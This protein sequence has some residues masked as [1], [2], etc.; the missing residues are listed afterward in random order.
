M[1]GRVVALDLSARHNVTSA[2]RDA[3]ALA[4]VADAGLG[5]RLLDVSDC[6]ALVEAVLDFDLV[7][8]AVPGSLGF[9]TLEAVIRAGRNVVDISFFPENALELQELATEHGVVAIVDSGVA[10][11]LDNLILGHHDRTMDVRS[12]E[13][14]VGGLPKR[15]KWPFEYKAPFSPIDVIEEYTRPARYLENGH[16][17]VRPALSDPELVWFKEVGTLES[18]NT[19]G[20]RTLISTMPHIPNMKE[21]TLRY[22]GHSSLI[23]AL[24][25]A[26]FFSE[27]AIQIDGRDVRPVDV[28]SRILIDEWKLDPAEPEFTIMRVTVVGSEQ[29]RDITYTYDLYDEFDSKT[30]FSSMA[31]TTG[32]T[33]TAM[34]NY[35]LDP[36]IADSGIYPLELVGRMVGGFGF[37]L[38][39]LTNHGVS[40]KGRR[41]ET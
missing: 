14:L 36:G 31:R 6:E 37:T 26:G 35:L 1:I 22:P 27:Q 7:V 23:R 5:T 30:G 8:G 12:F 4:S 10:P 38:K 17:I 16:E 29:G 11:G 39:H 18:F 3:D 34:V 15:R 28:T 24:K 25:E 32:F 21:K 41:S 19:D 20:L 9:R 13:C 40:L 2:D 33:C